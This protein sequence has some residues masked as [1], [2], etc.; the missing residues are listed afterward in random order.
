MGRPQ[1]LVVGTLTKDHLF[2]LKIHMFDPCPV[3]SRRAARG[4]HVPAMYI[5]AD[6]TLGICRNF[7]FFFLYSVFGFAARYMVHVC[8]HLAYI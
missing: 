2:E 5:T 1:P 6:H 8:G 4:D 7:S 3:V